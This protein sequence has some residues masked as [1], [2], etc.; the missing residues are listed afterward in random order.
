M[1]TKEALTT[2]GFFKNL[3]LKLMNGNGDR[4]AINQSVVQ[5]KKI[6]RMVGTYKTITIAP[7]PIVGG[8]VMRDVDPF[9]ILFSA[10][11]GMS[12]DI[13]NLVLDI[14]DETI[15]VLKANPYCVEEFE[16]KIQ[17]KKQGN[18]FAK[19]HANMMQSPKVF[20]SHKTEDA[21]YAKEIITMLV[22]LGVKHNDI[23][24][25]SVPG[26]GIPFG[27]SI[28]DSLRA[29]FDCY[30]LFVIFIHSPRYYNS[31]ISL[32]EM[33]AAWILRS[34]HCSFLTKDC[35]YDM[36][37]GVIN[38]DEI[39]FKA[40]QKSTEH[41]L[42]DFRKDIVE[43]FSLEPISDAV[44]DSTK[45]D[46]IDRVKAFSY[47]DIRLDTENLSNQFGMSVSANDI[48]SPESLIIGYLK[49]IGRDVKMSE[50]SA[51]T[52][53]PMGVTLRTLHELVNSKVVI[54]L[55]N[56]KYGKYRL[57]WNYESMLKMVKS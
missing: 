53:L 24:C 57:G 33:G 42:H 18:V 27:K 44:W 19:N 9:D 48:D 16:D 36:L 56:P 47:D 12:F 10:P 3:I 14:V 26:H 35:S 41:L 22:T 13:Y 11:Y 2:I 25:S 6:I 17:V 54:S 21:N 37:T 52:G 55:G 23:F 50:I 32:N 34:R 51:N 43:F 20:I 45:K 15:G 39:A 49:N 40:G 8:V 38:S 46:F 5:V 28:I 29:Q 7:P 31:A 4:S 1:T 30:K